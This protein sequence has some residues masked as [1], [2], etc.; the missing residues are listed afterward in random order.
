MEPLAPA[1][2]SSV[3]EPGVADAAE[4]ESSSDAVSVTI[5]SIAG[6]IVYGA[7]VHLCK[8]TLREVVDLMSS[9]EGLEPSLLL[10]FTKLEDEKTTLGELCVSPEKKLR[11][12]V[13]WQEEK[14]PRILIVSGAGLEACNGTYRRAAEEAK[15]RALWKNEATGAWI[16]WWGGGCGWEMFQRSDLFCEYFTQQSDSDQSL[17]YERDFSVCGPFLPAPIVRR[18]NVQRPR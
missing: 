9:P 2:S 10:G 5:E 15:G 17:P 8:T 6:D 1:A 7:V 4:A 11:F 14:I 13:V 12:S 16:Q 18:V 3:E